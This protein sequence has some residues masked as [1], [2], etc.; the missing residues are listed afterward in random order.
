M[1]GPV[2]V[3]KGKD[4]AEWSADS[5][6]PPP[7]QLAC[8]LADGTRVGRGLVGRGARA[9]VSTPSPG[10]QRER[11]G[12]TAL[13]EHGSSSFSSVLKPRCGCRAPRGGA[14]LRLHRLGL[15]RNARGPPCPAVSVP[16]RPRAP[17]SGLWTRRPGHRRSVAAAVPRRCLQPALTL[18]VKTR[19]PDSH[20]PRWLW[21][22]LRPL[23]TCPAAGRKDTELCPQRLHSPAAVAVPQ[24]CHFLGGKEGL[25]LHGLF[26]QQNI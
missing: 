3:F 26:L 8:V 6:A 13:E 12:T 15:L 4:R 5:E 18:C 16:R 25:P 21:N 22:S 10:T 14:A 19:N 24:R 2:C 23:Q 9:G 11:S 17:C 1:W 20:V 7:A